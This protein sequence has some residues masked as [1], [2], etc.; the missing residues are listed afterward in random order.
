MHKILREIASV[1][2]DVNMDGG[3]FSRRE[4]EQH[5]F[6][7]DMVRSALEAAFAAGATSTALVAVPP[8]GSGQR[9]RSPAGYVAVIGDAEQVD[10]NLT[11]HCTGERPA[12][13][14][15]RALAAEGEHITVI[16]PMGAVSLWLATGPAAA[17]SVGR[18]GS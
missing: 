16:S 8:V 5:C 6:T 10:R 12:A 1:H 2:L 3:T 13:L 11:M 17:P 4:M 18:L 9:W 14:A 15:A 7:F